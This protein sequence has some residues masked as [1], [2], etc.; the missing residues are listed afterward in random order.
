M[1][2]LRPFRPAALAGFAGLTVALLA[3]CS[4]SS[5]GRTPAASSGTPVPSASGSP[6]ASPSAASASPSASASPGL[7]AASADEILAQARRALLAAGTVHARGTVRSADVPYKLDLHLV[8][9]IGAI[10]SV[11]EQGTTLGVVRI[12][13]AAYVQLDQASWR[14]V[15]G[16]ATTA[17]RFAGKYLKVTASSGDAFKP[18]LALTDLD[19]VFDTLLVPPG[20]VTKGA[21]TTIGGRRVLDLPID[22]GRTGHVFVALDGTPYPVRLSYGSGHRPAGRP[23]RLRAQGRPRRPGRVQDRLLR[24]RPRLG[25]PG[26]SGC[27]PGVLSTPWVVCAGARGRPAAVPRSPR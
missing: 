18:F 26:A 24:F 7:A 23:R 16:N 6:S 27:G 11:A 20:S 22:G 9:K 13:N 10:G 4:G 21:A 15:T 12:K 19:Q 8:R 3:A 1:A 17:R 2:C 14:A 25:V 5:S